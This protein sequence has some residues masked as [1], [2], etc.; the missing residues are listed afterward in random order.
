LLGFRD[1]RGLAADLQAFLPR[2]DR[3]TQGLLDATKVLV[4]RPEERAQLLF[5]A[6]RD[7]VFSHRGVGYFVYGG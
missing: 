7:E 2:D 1:H 3:D 6:K 4:M 5:V